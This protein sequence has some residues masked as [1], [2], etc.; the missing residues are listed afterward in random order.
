MNRLLTTSLKTLSV[1]GLIA[2]AS[3][4]AHALPHFTFADFKVGDTLEVNGVGRD[5]F[6]PGATFIARVIA[7]QDHEPK[8]RIRMLTVP[9]ATRGGF[10][11]DVY[12]YS[13]KVRAYTNAF[14]DEWDAKNWI[15]SWYVGT[16]LAMTTRI[17]GDYEITEK[18]LITASGGLAIRADGT[19]Q[20]HPPVG[21]PVQGTWVK[22]TEPDYALILKKAKGGADYGVAPYGKDEQGRLQIY[23]KDTNGGFWYAGPRV[24]RGPAV[25]PRKATPTQ[26]AKPL[27]I[28]SAESPA[29]PS[30]PA[31][32]PAPADT[33]APVPTDP[34]APA[35]APAEPPA[36]A[37]AVT[38]PPATTPKFNV[39]DS[40][41]V[42]QGVG[43]KVAKVLEAVADGY[44]V[45]YDD[46]G[47]TP[48]EMA[49]SIRVRAVDAPIAGAEMPL[50]V[51]TR[52][53]ALHKFVTGKFALL[54]GKVIEEK[55]E[56]VII[57]CDGEGDLKHPDHYV[58][59]PA[60]RLE[61]N[62]VRVLG[63]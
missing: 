56:S 4:N 32:P 62:V 34:P 15:G 12:V 24:G 21:G 40:V 45:N 9:N 48:D 16:D 23:L 22:S 59:G 39:G 6:K 41:E 49:I 26:K 38:D 58:T 43:W 5:D 3:P 14:I 13:N 27:N 60:K 50:T 61:S 63:P 57:Q 42:F 2:C 28:A 18:S 51:G 30:T 17:K 33:P 31:A 35:P 55:G 29:E 46:R 11:R 52:L 25:A 53:E 7:L 19:Y 37:R 44:K 54:K 36:P 10:Y 20:W 8:Y 1:A 47:Y